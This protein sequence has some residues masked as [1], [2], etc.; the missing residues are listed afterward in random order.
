MVLNALCERLD[1][2]D[3]QFWESHGFCD[4]TDQ[5]ISWFASMET[6]RNTV[7]VVPGLLA[8]RAQEAFAVDSVK[9]RRILDQLIAQLGSEDG[10]TSATYLILS[11][12]EAI[13]ADVAD[14]LPH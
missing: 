7:S 6:I 10:Q 4:L 3:E 8:Y 12:T 2:A 13:K 1:Y 11:M 5:E 14:C 9:G